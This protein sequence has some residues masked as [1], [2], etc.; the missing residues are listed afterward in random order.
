MHQK[1]FRSDIQN[2]L[3]IPLQRFIFEPHQRQDSNMHSKTVS[4]KLPGRRTGPE[5][6]GRLL[7]ND[8][9]NFIQFLWHLWILWKYHTN[10][11][12]IIYC[13]KNNCDYQSL[14]SYTISM[15]KSFMYKRAFTA[16]VKRI[17][18]VCA[19]NS[20]IY[21]FSD[22]YFCGYF[23]AGYLPYRRKY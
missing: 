15:Y 10:D 9:W 23:T 20:D 8:P 12:K 14:T 11:K 5:T 4:F 17:K 6:H 2:L 13:H 3:K 16:V 22:I 1:R 19:P 21:F 7:Q 18:P